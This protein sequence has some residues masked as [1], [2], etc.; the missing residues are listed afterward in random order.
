MS[1]P[2]AHQSTAL[3]YPL[4]RMISGARYSGVPHSVHVLPFTRFAKPKSV[5]C[6]VEFIVNVDYLAS[7]YF[8]C[9]QGSIL[10][11]LA[12]PLDWS[13]GRQR[14]NHSKNR[15]LNIGNRLHARGL[16]ASLEIPPYL[17]IPSSLLTHLQIAL[18][19]DEKVLWLKVAVDEVQVVEVLER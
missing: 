7:C 3:L 11:A 14:R 2:S 18:V 6:K 17:P 10:P 16:A 8:P 15:I 13:G 4:L 5:I 19:V 9:W 12:R 1:T